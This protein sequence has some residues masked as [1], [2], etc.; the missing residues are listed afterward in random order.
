M[1]RRGVVIFPFKV[2]EIHTENTKHIRTRTMTYPCQC[3]YWW[4]SHDAHYALTQ[5]FLSYNWATSWDE[6]SDPWILYTVTT[7]HKRQLTSTV[8]ATPL[9]TPTTDLGL[10]IR[11]SM[12][13]VARDW[14]LGHL[15]RS[16]GTGEG[17]DWWSW[18]MGIKAEGMLRVC[19]GESSNF[20]IP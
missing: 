12:F 17:G 10:S 6:P 18:P 11:L 13:R 3:L 2:V 4:H 7:A 1:S 14:W 15:P 20:R 5:Y 8:Y 16:P 9:M 19:Q